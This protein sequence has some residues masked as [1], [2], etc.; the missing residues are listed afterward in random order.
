MS[1]INTRQLA[2]DAMLAAMCAVLGYLSI[3]LNNLKFTFESVPILIGALLFGPA[4]GAAIGLVGTLIYQLLRYGVSATTVL[5]IAPYVLC[6]VLVGWYAKRRRFELNQTQTVVIV[7]L[8]ELLVTLLNT[9]V[10]YVDSKLYGYYTPTLITGALALRL[11]ICV[12]KALVY[13]FA[14]PPLLSAL[15]R[16]GR[17]GKKEGAI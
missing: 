4:D 17:V 10:I 6:G 11:L 14:L 3:D 9:G 5:W 1:K 7:V 15:R 2:I 16:G 8:G 13:S 12:G